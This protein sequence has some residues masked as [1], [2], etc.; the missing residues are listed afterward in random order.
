[1]TRKFYEV[2]KRALLIIAGILFVYMFITYN[3]NL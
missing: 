3:K 2:P 1:M